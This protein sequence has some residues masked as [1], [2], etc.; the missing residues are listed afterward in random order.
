METPVKKNESPLNQVKLDTTISN[1][2]T[3]TNLLRLLVNKVVFLDLNSYKPLSKVKDCLNLIGSVSSLSDFV[4]MF[5]NL[6]NLDVDFNIED[7]RLSK[8]RC[9]LCNHQ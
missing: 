6:A 7:C 2:K 4:V 3:H 9:G 5:A 1:A 8:Q